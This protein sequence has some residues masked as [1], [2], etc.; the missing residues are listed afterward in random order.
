LPKVVEDILAKERPDQ[1]ERDKTRLVTY[2]APHNSAVQIYDYK[3]KKSRV[4]FGP[5]LVMLG[6]DE[7]FT[8]L[9]LSGDQP[10]KP[11]VIKALCLLLGPDFMTDVVIVET[12]DHARLSLKL[13]Y[14]W[15]FELDKNKIDEAHKIFQVPDFVGDSCKAIASRVRGAV[16]GV[17]FDQFHKNSAQ[18]I[19]NAV[20]GLDEKNILRNKFKFSSNNLAITNIDVQSVEPVD[21]RTRDS[22]AKSVQLAIEITTSSLEAAA[23]QDS[24]RLEQE[25]LGRLERQK[26]NDEAEAEKS[27][28]Q[29]LTLQAE[30]HS[31]E[32]TGQASAE[33]KAKAEAAYI[34]G[35]ASVK[36]AQLSAQATKIKTEA[37]LNTTKMRQEAEITFQKAKNLL[38]IQ[39]ARDLANIE[40]KKFKD[41]VDS[42]GAGTIK[43]MAEAGPSMQAK[44]LSGLGLKSFLITDGNSPINLFNTASG[45]LGGE[46]K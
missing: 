43:A 34:E 37:E 40:E 21:Q 1:G 7:H 39:R 15:Q 26:I 31:V 30:T 4:I 17:S 2:R 38:E 5:D 29:L 41:I 18:V 42:I 22:L 33:A 13:S 12:A 25:A 6:P 11:D 3:E 14:N 16:A 45:L 36:Q 23:K 8:V 19:R 20:F 24:A 46:S 9:S 10:K 27:R 35:E 32:S 28:K 44:L